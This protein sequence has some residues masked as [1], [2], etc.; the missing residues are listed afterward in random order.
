MT[1]TP[2]HFLDDKKSFFKTH[3]PP[4]N[5][6]N[7]KILCFFGK[8]AHKRRNKSENRQNR[9]N[10]REKYKKRRVRLKIGI[11]AIIK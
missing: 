1:N 9:V 11:G 10:N 2:L 3:P 4:S 5:T 7:I 6:K 8:N